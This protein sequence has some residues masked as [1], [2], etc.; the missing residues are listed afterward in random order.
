MRVTHAVALT[1]VLLSVGAAYVRLCPCGGSARRRDFA[2]S[3]FGSS[4][5]WDGV[6]VP[7]V[8]QRDGSRLLSP[9]LSAVG[10]TASWRL[11]VELKP[12]WGFLPSSPFLAP[13]TAAAKRSVCRFCMHQLYKRTR[14]DSPHCHT[15][16]HTTPTVLSVV[17]LLTLLPCCAAVCVGSRDGVRLL[18]ARPVLW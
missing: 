10:S 2:A 14:G 4:T 9:L 7:A 11:A 5:E 12:K 13:R 8:L 6:L 1:G 15:H 18:S 16:S 17:L 3:L